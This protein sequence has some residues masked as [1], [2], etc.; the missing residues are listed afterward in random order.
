MADDNEDK[1]HKALMMAL[2]KMQVPL[3]A[4]AL[5]KLVD[6]FYTKEERAKVYA[7]YGKLRD[8]DDAAYANLEQIRAADNLSREQRIEK[9]GEA[10]ANEQLAPFQAAM[11]AKQETSRAVMAFQKEHRLVRRLLDMCAT[12]SKGKYD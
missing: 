4:L 9:Y 8:A 11:E 6:E 3:E 12:L 2:E 7:E 10:K 5:L 1:Q